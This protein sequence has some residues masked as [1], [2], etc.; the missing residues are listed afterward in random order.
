M[1]HP[2]KSHVSSSAERE[3]E[4]LLRRSR[5][6]LETAKFQVEGGMLALAALS[7]EQAL[8]LFLKARLLERG[9]LY[10]RIHDV[11]RLIEMLVEVDPNL[12]GLN[13]LLK[14][15]QVELSLL[16]D[17]YI[18]SRYIPKDFSEDEVRRL[19]RVV[20]EVMRAVPPVS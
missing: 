10:P 17:A 7:L 19:F 4:Y 15:Y 6:F 12:K 5:E 13:E 11:R 2:P 16:E 1:G 9:V 8:Q 3:V 14:K 20:E 18:T